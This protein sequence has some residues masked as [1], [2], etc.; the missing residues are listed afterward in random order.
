LNSSFES[1][2][3]GLS[4]AD[5]DA[6]HKKRAALDAERVKVGEQLVK[7]NRLMGELPGHLAAKRQPEL[8]LLNAG[9]VSLIRAISS[10]DT[11]ITA[12]EQRAATARAQ[13][14]TLEILG[15]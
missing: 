13:A 1:A 4:S 9:Y 10:V 3:T 11:A 6:L 8:D 15:G 14:R 7:L 12:A 2:I 5:A